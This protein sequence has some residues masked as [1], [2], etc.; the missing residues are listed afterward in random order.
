MSHFRKNGQKVANLDSFS[1]YCNNW[2]S[3]G[4]IIN[5][6]TLAFFLWIH[7]L[8]YWAKYCFDV[9]TIA[10]FGSFC[11]NDNGTYVSKGCAKKYY[12]YNK[13]CCREVHKES[14]CDW[15]I[16][17]KEKGNICVRQG[18]SEEDVVELTRRYHVSK[19]NKGFSRTITTVVSRYLRKD[20]EPFYLMIYNCD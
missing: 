3:Y 18:V 2:K 4:R 13:D 8:P 1:P 12:V 17:V 5:P 16:L 7:L 6:G 11:K 10:H 15:F 20:V 19:N 9:T 14:N